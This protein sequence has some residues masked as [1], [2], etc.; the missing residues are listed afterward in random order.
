MVRIGVG[1]HAHPRSCD[2]QRSVAFVVARYRGVNGNE[3]ASL[4]MLQ[5][6]TTLTV[7]SFYLEPILTYLE[8]VS[9]ICVRQGVCYTNFC[10]TTGVIFGI[11]DFQ[12]PF[13]RATP[14]SEGIM[15][16]PTVEPFLPIACCNS[17]TAAP[18]FS[19]QTTWH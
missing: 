12:T 3:E 15:F 1:C 16:P 17:L 10:V 13:V 7:G 18:A 5:E 6:H 8:P 11:K 14:L 2:V 9:L 19:A 4:C